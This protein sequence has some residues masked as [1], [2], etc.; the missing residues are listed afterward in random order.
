MNIGSFIAQPVAAK[1]V[2]VV[3]KVLPLFPYFFSYQ[4]IEIQ[5]S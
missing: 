1:K 4:L 2:I 3:L 5:L